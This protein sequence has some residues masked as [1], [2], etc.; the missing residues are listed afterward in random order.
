MEKKISVLVVDDEEIV[1]I[2]LEE[3]LI[4]EGFKVFSTISG[5]DAIEILRSH[6]IDIGI[7]DMRLPGMDG[8]SLII[9]AKKI[10]PNIKCV[11]HT[12]SMSYSIPETLE[13]LGVSEDLVFKKPI[14]DIEHFVEILKSLVR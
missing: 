8:N 14:K 1:R 13:R 5:E 12:G 11:I 10:R 4:D 7:I 6:D 2:F 3:Y 9:E